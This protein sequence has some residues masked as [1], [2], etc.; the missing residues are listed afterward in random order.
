MKMPVG[1]KFVGAVSKDEVRHLPTN[2]LTKVP[3]IDTVS[4]DPQ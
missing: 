1:W 4:L 2:V 3:P